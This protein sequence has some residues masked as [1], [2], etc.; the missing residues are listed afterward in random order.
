[1]DIRA[2]RY[3]QA[4]YEELSLSAAAKRCFVAQPSI[5][6]AIQQLESELDTP[7]FIRNSKGVTPTPAG[8]KLYP[9]ASKLVS[10]LQ[11]IKHQ[12]REPAAPLPLRIGLMPF[13]SGQRLSL[14]LKELSAQLPA[15]E[16]TL[17]DADSPADARIIASNQRLPGEVFH[18]LW[19]DHYVL[20]LPLDHPLG[21]LGKL[22]LQHLEGV[23]FISRSFCDVL[24]A[25]HFALQRQNV[26]L[27][28]K[29]RVHTE[30]YALDLVAAGM[31]VSLVPLS[32]VEGRSQIVTREVGNIDMART[33]GLAYAKD[34]PLPDALLKAIQQVRQQLRLPEA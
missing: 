1:M 30:E 19:D 6:S 28:I 20:A 13:L 24:E 32:S 26:Q 5:S 11:E 22:G 31:G 7:L 27:S 10:D 8:E 21:R 15:L 23:P 3:F 17:V 18:K 12:F 25:W 9:L 14:L 34:R 16:L 33:V 4:V 2:L 29:A